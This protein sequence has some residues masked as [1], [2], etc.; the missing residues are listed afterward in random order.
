ME[1]TNRKRGTT[2]WAD[3]GD[4][5]LEVWIRGKEML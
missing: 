2:Q 5:L 4:E 3:R 1:Y